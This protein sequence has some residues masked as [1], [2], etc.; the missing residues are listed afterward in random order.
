MLYWT[1]RCFDDDKN[2]VRITNKSKK[3]V[4]VLLNGQNLK[5]TDINMMNDYACLSLEQNHLVHANEQNHFKL[6]IHAHPS[7]NDTCVTNFNSVT[8]KSSSSIVHVQIQVKLTW[9]KVKCLSNT[10][11]LEGL[12]PIHLKL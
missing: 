10:H 4:K 3:C 1:S 9:E 5:S 7:N 12:M 2:Q 8:G 11:S 6:V